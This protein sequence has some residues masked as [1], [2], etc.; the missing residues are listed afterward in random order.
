MDCDFGKFCDKD[1]CNLNHPGERWRK[2]NQY[3]DCDN[4][5]C[6]LRHRW[7]QPCNTTKNGGKCTNK[8]CIYSHDS[9][10]IKYW[11][12][13]EEF[14]RLRLGPCRN[15]KDCR[16]KNCKYAH[17]QSVESKQESK[18]NANVDRRELCKFF[19]T[20]NRCKYGD[21]CIFKHEQRGSRDQHEKVI[22]AVV[23]IPMAKPKETQVTKVLTTGQKTL[24]MTTFSGDPE[25][26]MAAFNKLAI[27]K[28]N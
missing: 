13:K 15:G 20:P 25:S 22:R 23:E 27:A 1:E 10:T 11:V 24:T 18:S 7:D 26:V 28:D 14:H 2:C 4:R 8:E 19:G 17:E 12:D 9:E 3:T 5:D 21:K 6:K 16:R